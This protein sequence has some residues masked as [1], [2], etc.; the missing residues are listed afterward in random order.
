VSIPASPSH[1]LTGED[2][3]VLADI[4]RG[5]P[6]SPA[7]LYQQRLRNL[8]GAGYLLWDMATWDYLLTNKALEAL[9]VPPAEPGATIEPAS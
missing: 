7:F 3:R 9:K 4:Q 8:A 2:Y 5:Y 1:R 6:Q